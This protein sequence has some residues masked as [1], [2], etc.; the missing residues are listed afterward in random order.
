MA[1][2]IGGFL[3]DP[4]PLTNSCKSEVSVQSVVVADPVGHSSAIPVPM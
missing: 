2:T 4:E 3:Q 1:R